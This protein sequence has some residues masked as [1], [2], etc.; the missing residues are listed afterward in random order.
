M[1]SEQ[2]KFKSQS[3]GVGPMIVDTYSSG[4]EICHEIKVGHQVSLETDDLT[5]LVRVNK[6]EGESYI[7]TIDSFENYIEEGYKGYKKG[8]KVEFTYSEIHGCIAKI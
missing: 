2:I 8:D 4:D 6:I 7:G 5:V 1:E 3:Y